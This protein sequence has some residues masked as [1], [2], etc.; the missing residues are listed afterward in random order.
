M[1]AHRAIDEHRKA[2]FRAEGEI[3]KETADLDFERVFRTKRDPDHS[4]EG[5]LLDSGA[6]EG[7]DEMNIFAS[8]MSSKKPPAELEGVG[9]PV[10][11]PVAPASTTDLLKC[12][13]ETR[14]EKAIDG[15]YQRALNGWKAFDTA[16]RIFGKYLD[17]QDPF[18]LAICSLR[19]EAFEIFHG[20][21]PPSGIETF[22]VTMDLKLRAKS[23]LPLSV[24][25]TDF[26]DAIS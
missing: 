7:P 3:Q 24:G 4:M 8:D 2:L 21:S 9:V 12:F 5:V 23:L 13:F 15:Y 17:K 19:A 26:P 22:S 20:E 1:L 10:P 25:S 18:V 16:I 11:K 14:L 6:Q